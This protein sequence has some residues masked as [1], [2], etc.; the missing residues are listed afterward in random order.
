MKKTTKEK[1]AY[2]Y[3]GSK[4][5]RPKM[6]LPP[7]PKGFNLK[8]LLNRAEKLNE[9]GWLD[10]LKKP[11]FPG[12]SEY[13]RQEAQYVADEQR[14]KEIIPLGKERTTEEIKKE[15]QH[16][17]EMRRKAPNFGED[18][19]WPMRDFGICNSPYEA[20]IALDMGRD[21]VYVDL[22]CPDKKLKTLFAEN[23]KLLRQRAAARAK[24]YATATKPDLAVWRHNR[25]LPYHLLVRNG[26]TEKHG[27]AE[28]AAWI[29]PE[30]QNTRARWKRL[31]ETKK[32]Y[33]QALK[34]L[35]ALEINADRN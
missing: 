27:N 33:A 9:R 12:T 24:T 26:L 7:P 35:H 28:I 22:R 2:D 23:L 18:L 3:Y 21:L 25:I 5:G 31:A 11:P 4:A 13:Q 14:R 29:F 17:C 8:A 32:A 30:I 16:G 10:E 1:K 15:F 19:L 20:E 6:E 34:S